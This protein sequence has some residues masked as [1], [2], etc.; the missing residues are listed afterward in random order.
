M[1]F[2]NIWIY[3]SIYYV[4]EF[5]TLY[6]A[7]VWPYVQDWLIIWCFTLYRQ[8]LSHITTSFI[9]IDFLF[10]III[11]L[12]M[13]LLEFKWLK[14]QLELSEQFSHID[15]QL[16]TYANSFIKR[17]FKAHIVWFQ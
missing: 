7:V 13:R 12:V 2:C 1:V 4:L 17:G 15:V 16:E 3:V 6:R 14:N 8:H 5:D 10:D 11:K 9:Q